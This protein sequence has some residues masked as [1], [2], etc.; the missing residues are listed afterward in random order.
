MKPLN[1][2]SPVSTSCSA[3][4]D[5]I[6]SKGVH[7]DLRAKSEDFLDKASGQTTGIW[8]NGKE[9]LNYMPTTSTSYAITNN[10]NNNNNNNNVYLLGCFFSCIKMKQKLKD[11]L[12]KEDLRL[13]TN[14]EQIKQE[15]KKERKK[16]RKERNEQAMMQGRKR[17]EKGKGTK[18]WRRMERHSKSDQKGKEERQKRRKAGRKKKK[19]D[20]KATHWKHAKCM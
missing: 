13:W 3:R 7:I 18:I 17:T 9:S 10:N 4:N 14:K 8:K 15:R 20:E 11:Y 16:R 19:I 12:Q 6:V 2:P 1:S 5:D